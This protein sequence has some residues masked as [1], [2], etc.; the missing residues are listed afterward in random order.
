M[1]SMMTHYQ[2]GAMS[3]AFCEHQAEKGSLLAHLVD[4]ASLATN[5]RLE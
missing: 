3:Q 2:Q 5:L 4:G 1:N